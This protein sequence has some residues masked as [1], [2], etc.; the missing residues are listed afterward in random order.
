MC[1]DGV[2][3][4][5]IILCVVERDGAIVASALIGKYSPPTKNSTESVLSHEAAHISRELFCFGAIW[6]KGALRLR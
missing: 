2:S 3:D 4:H 1:V 5:F 6:C